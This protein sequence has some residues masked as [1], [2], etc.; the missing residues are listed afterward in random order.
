MS[1][2]AYH[3]EHLTNMLLEEL[4]SVPGV[5]LARAPAG[6]ASTSTVAFT[7]PSRRPLD[8]AAACDAW[9]LWILLEGPDSV[10]GDNSP[11]RPAELHGSLR[12][13]LRANVIMK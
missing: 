1:A 3:E 6:V 8:I 7:A 2:F 5:R 9:P 4:T 13:K 11:I 10:E 12:G